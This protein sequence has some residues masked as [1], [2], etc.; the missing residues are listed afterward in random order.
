MKKRT[1]RS[2][3]I[4]VETVAY[5]LI[6]LVLISLVLA[7]ATPAI[8]KQKD[9]AV[10]DKTI[11]AMTEMDNAVSN[12]KRTGVANNQQIDFSIS[13]GELIINALENKT[14]FRIEDVKYAYSEVGRKVDLNSDM[15]VKT[16]ESG[17]NYEVEITLDY[18]DKTDLKY[19]YD[20]NNPLSGENEKTLV[21]AKTPYRLIIEN[22]GKDDPAKA[23]RIN[24]Y[25]VS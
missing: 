15:S 2:A 7:F 24:I 20:I 11:S 13:K 19:D 14:I 5:T 22:L 1:N 25:S 8:Q 6:G 4:W 17:K 16:T 10:I 23:I 21:K 9:N 12:V 18:G 3:Q